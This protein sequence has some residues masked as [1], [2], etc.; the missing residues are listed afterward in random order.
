MTCKCD[1]ELADHFEGA[2]QIAECSCAAFL[3]R[4]PRVEA[5]RGHEHDVVFRLTVPYEDERQGFPVYRA[6]TKAAAD[7]GVKAEV[8]FSS[9]LTDGSAFYRNCSSCNQTMTLRIEEWGAPHPRT[10][11]MGA[12]WPPEIDALYRLAGWSPDAPGSRFW[13]C[14]ACKPS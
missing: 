5:E 2:C 3:P 14:G 10:F 1:H 12:P 13:K 8:E 11:D 9:T 6:M 4:A 7:L